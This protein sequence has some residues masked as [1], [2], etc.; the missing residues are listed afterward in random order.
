[1]AGSALWTVAQ[2]RVIQGVQIDSLQISAPY[3]PEEIA[4]PIDDPEA[5]NMAWSKKQAE[6]R[7]KILARYEKPST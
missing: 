2:H 1:M 5:R 4:R 3:D 6:R 7:R